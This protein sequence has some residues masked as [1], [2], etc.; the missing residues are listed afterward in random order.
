MEKD[1]VVILCLSASKV[2]SLVFLGGDFNAMIR[3]CTAAWS[4]HELM[5]SICHGILNIDALERLESH[6]I[7]NYLEI[8]SSPWLQWR[9]KQ[10]ARHMYKEQ[11]TMKRLG[12]KSSKSSIIFHYVASIADR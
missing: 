11:E 10:E 2:L 9:L 6:Q 7:S 4:L 3:F 1:F 12:S 8:A 5:L